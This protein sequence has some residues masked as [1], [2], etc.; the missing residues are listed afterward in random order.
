MYPATWTGA[1]AGYWDGQCKQT[2]AEKQ[3]L[4]VLSLWEG[5]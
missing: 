4:E 3:K 1:H 2:V 5:L